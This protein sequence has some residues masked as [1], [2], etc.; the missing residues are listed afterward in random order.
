MDAKTQEKRAAQR[1]Q[2]RAKHR[3]YYANH[4]DAIRLRAHQRYYQKVH[5]LAEAPPLRANMATLLRQTHPP[6]VP[7][8]GV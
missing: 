7:E 2:E 4:R 1:E 5:G 6:P 3:R 8:G